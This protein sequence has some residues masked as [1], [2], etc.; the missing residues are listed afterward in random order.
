MALLVKNPFANAGDI[1]TWVWS[2]GQ[3]DYPGEGHGKPL[4]YSCLEN[5]MDRGD[6]QATVHRVTQNQIRLKQISTHRKINILNKVKKSRWNTHVQKVFNQ[7]AHPRIR[8]TNFLYLWLPVA[9]GS[10]DGRHQQAV[11]DGRGKTRV[12]VPS[13]QSPYGFE[14]SVHLRPWLQFLRTTLF[15]CPF[16]LKIVMGPH[17][18]QEEGNVLSSIRLLTPGPSSNHCACPHHSL[19]YP[20]WVCYLFPSGM[21]TDATVHAL[22][23][24]EEQ[25]AYTVACHQTLPLER[26]QSW[27]PASPQRSPLSWILWFSNISLL[28]KK[29]KNSNFFFLE[30][31]KWYSD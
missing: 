18:R 25:S 1:E 16:Q 14:A 15:F 11:R 17:G 4:Q 10:A 27:L 29:K 12:F 26:Y 24:A 23:K 8:S 5:P 30:L 3:E 9:L 2:L 6:Y 31:P 22:D 28:Y 13:M 21:L 19:N 7:E 20:L